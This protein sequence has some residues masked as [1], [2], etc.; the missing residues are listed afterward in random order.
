MSFACAWVV[1]L[2][3]LGVGS[4]TGEDDADDEG[5]ST[6]RRRFLGSGSP[7]AGKDDADPAA[8]AMIE[9]F[10]LQ[11]LRQ[12]NQVDKWTKKYELCYELPSSGL[13]TRWETS[14]KKKIPFWCQ[15]GA[16]APIAPTLAPPLTAPDL[17]RRNS[18]H[19]QC[20]LKHCK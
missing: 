5:D 10:P 8:S 19:D 2:R 13:D 9:C 12:N 3:C 7:T 18:H 17:N 11:T 1:C 14:I 6:I 16:V 4:G 20:I 15:V